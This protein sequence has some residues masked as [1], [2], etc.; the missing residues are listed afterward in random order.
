MQN[1]AST[2]EAMTQYLGL[3]AKDTTASV[4]LTLRLHG[5]TVH[6]VDVNKQTRSML[7]HGAPRLCSM[8]HKRE[9]G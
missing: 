1:P 8:R 7:L 6:D 5:T 4:Y 3:R 2:T 9:A